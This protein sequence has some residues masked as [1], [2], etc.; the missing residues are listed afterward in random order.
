[1]TDDTEVIDL[2]ARRRVADLED[3]VSSLRYRLEYRDRQQ[4]EKTAASVGFTIGFTVGL[5][6]AIVVLAARKRRADPG[7]TRLADQV[8]G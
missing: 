8:D 2:I 6:I 3:G 1:M 5:Y 7:A 4:A